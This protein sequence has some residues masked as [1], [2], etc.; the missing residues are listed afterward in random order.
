MQHSRLN[1]QLDVVTCPQKFTRVNVV[2]PSVTICHCHIAAT[3][4]SVTFTT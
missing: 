4:G 1:I 3:G 2:A